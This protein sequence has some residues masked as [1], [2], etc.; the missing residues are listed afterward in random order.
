MLLK[1]T[2]Y[3]ELNGDEGWPWIFMNNKRDQFGPEIS[4]RGYKHYWCKNRLHGKYIHDM[5]AY[6][7]FDVRS[8]LHSYGIY[9]LNGNIKDVGKENSVNE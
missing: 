8:G 4:T 9:F 7:V 2:S 6:F 1:K 5:T 3:I